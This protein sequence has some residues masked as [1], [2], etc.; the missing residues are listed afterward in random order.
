M[1]PFNAKTAPRG[2]AC[3]VE[4]VDVLY[5]KGGSEEPPLDCLPDRNPP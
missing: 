3:N 2:T 5:E 4:L 1:G